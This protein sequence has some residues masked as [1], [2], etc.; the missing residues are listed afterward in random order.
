MSCS[1]VKFGLLACLTVVVLAASPVSAGLIGS[2]GFSEHSLTPSD[3]DG[4]DGITFSNF[5]I[6]TGYGDLTDNGA[7]ANALRLSGDDTENFSSNA[8][9]N[10]AFLSFTITVAAGWQL[11]LTS[12]EFDNQATNAYLYS[13]GRVFSDVLGFDNI[14]DDTIGRVGRDSTGSDAL[15]HTDLIDLDDPTNNVANGANAASS[16]GFDLSGAA[17]ITFYLPWIDKSDSDTRFTDLHEIRINGTATVPEPSSLVLMGGLIA[18][19][20]LRWSVVRGRRRRL[21]VA[22]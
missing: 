6:G 12:I 15:I 8:F 2:Y 13:S 7:L 17:T 18:L 9:S 22:Q 21:G 5:V 20:M 19:V 3:A 10:D 16:S 4:G 1:K 14:V 11:D